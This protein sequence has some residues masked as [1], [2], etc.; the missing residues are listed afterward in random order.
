MSIDRCA[1][2]T[3]ANQAPVVSLTSPANG[4][5]YSAPATVPLA[6]S[7]TD[8]KAVTRVEFYSGT[9]L[10]NTDTTAPYSFNWTGVAAGTYSV[11]ATAYDGDGASS[12]TAAATISVAAAASPPTGV[13]FQKSADHDT[14]VTSYELRVF[15]NGANPNTATPVAKVDLGKPAP[16]ANGDITSSQP[17][18]FSNLAVGTYVAAVA[19]LGSGGASISTA[20]RSP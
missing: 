1:A 15:P 11:H 14:L 10:L 19:A 16:A 13:V 7:A 4:T 8:D 3:P 20:V 18:F 6:A 12:T 17:T 2:A 9:T 5:S